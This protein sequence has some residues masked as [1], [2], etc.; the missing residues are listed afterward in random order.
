MFAAEGSGVEYYEDFGVKFEV[1]RYERE[2]VAG[3]LVRGMVKREEWASWLGAAGLP[4][5]PEVGGIERWYDG[6]RKRPW[7]IMWTG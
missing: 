3:D 4:V 2:R 1:G 5:S 7:E 6:E